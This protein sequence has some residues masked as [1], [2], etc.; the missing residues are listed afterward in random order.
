MEYGGVVTT[1]NQLSRLG[2]SH[3]MNLFKA[4]PD[5]SLTEIVKILGHFTRFVDMDM[6]EEITSHVTQAEVEGTL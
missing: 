1:F 2:N 3:F 5:A 6:V 4:P